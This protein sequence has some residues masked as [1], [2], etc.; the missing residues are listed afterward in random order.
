[1]IIGGI[2]LTPAQTVRAMQL[3]A[4]AAG[5]DFLTDDQAQAFLAEAARQV[6]GASG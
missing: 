6:T 2:D 1:M 5:D 4:Q 3:A